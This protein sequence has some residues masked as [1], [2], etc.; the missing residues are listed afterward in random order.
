MFV[1]LVWSKLQQLS[2][3]ISLTL[4]VVPF[5]CTALSVCFSVQPYCSCRHKGSCSLS[6]FSVVSDKQKHLCDKHLRAL[7]KQESTSGEH[8]CFYC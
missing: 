1:G 8:E 5:S 4:C 2:W 7:Q 3:S 6:G